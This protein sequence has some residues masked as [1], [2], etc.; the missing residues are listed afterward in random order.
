MDAELFDL[1]RGGE[2]VET[3]LGTPPR[4]V[5]GSIYLSALLIVVGMVWAYSTSLDVVIEAT[6]VVRPRGDLL[7]VQARTSGILLE[8]F[9]E[10]GQTVGA[11]DVLFRIDGRET[12]SELE[13]VIGRKKAVDK[14]LSALRASRATLIEQQGAELE[15]DQIGAR[16]AQGEF[17]K[18]KLGEEQAAAALREVESRLGE[19]QTD[20]DQTEILAH[21]NILSQAELKKREAQLRGVQAAIDS[22]TAGYL[23]AVET[24]ALSSEAVELWHKQTEVVSGERKQALAELDSRIDSLQEESEEVE[25]QANKLRSALDCLSVRAPLGGTVTALMSRHAGE[26]VR[27]GDTLARIAVEGVPWVVEALVTNRDIGALQARIGGPVKLKI[28]AFPYREYGTVEGRV[29]EV[30]PDSIAHEG[31]L[32]GFKVEVGLDSLQLARGA[33]EGRIGLGMTATVEIWVAKERILSL[34]FKGIRGRIAFD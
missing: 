24:M 2:S 34:L 27:T 19:A 17:R 23:I 22:A 6:G 30:S 8:A 21:E 10:E 15:R 9:V 20:F 18:A 28:D 32:S 25:L 26:M 5:R 4:L 16:T 7:S 1:E 11:S 14:Q 12:Q 13:R 33:K 3:M 31:L 29:L